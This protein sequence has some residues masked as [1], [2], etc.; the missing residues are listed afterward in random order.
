VLV[1][2]GVDHER[3]LDEL[4]AAVEDRGV[5][6]ELPDR[7]DLEQGADALPRLGQRPRLGRVECGH[8]FLEL[9]RGD[10][11]EG[12]QIGD[13][14]G[15]KSARRTDRVDKQTGR[16]GTGEERGGIPGLQAAV[17]LG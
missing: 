11:H 9:Q 3:H 13:G 14:V 7:R 4:E 2:Q 1:A 17:G 5:E 12:H 6:G 10:R 16:T 8:R 15:H